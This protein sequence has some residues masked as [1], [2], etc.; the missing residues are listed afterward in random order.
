MEITDYWDNT[1]QKIKELERSGIEVIGIY[2]GKKYYEE[3]RQNAKEFFERR[4]VVRET[5]PIDLLVPLLRKM[6][7]R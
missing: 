2:R 7:V 3:A 4:V 5:N 6:I 1:M